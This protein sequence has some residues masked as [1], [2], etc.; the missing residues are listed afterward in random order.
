MW[1][2]EYEIKYLWIVL[3]MLT[4]A[5]MCLLWLQYLISL[6]SICWI[7]LGNP[8]SSYSQLSCL[9]YSI[10][11]TDTVT[12]QL[13]QFRGVECVEIFILIYHHHLF[14]AYTWLWVYKISHGVW[15]MAGNSRNAQPCSA[16]TKSHGCMV[17]HAIVSRVCPAHALFYL[18]LYHFTKWTLNK[19]LPLCGN[20]I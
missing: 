20:I 13:V 18:S 6:Q 15:R 12:C 9:F 5:R 19:E 2:P 10:Q 17:N 14:V 1:A 11:Y 7:L 4:G 3:P 16:V 8:M